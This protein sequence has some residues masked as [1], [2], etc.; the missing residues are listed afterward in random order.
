MKNKKA[1]KDNLYRQ[2]KKPDK[3]FC[4]PTNKME[5]V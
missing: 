2:K 1:S 3:I 5:G 4:H